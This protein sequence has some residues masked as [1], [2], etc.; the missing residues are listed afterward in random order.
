MVYVPF[1]RAVLFKFGQSFLARN[2]LTPRW[3]LDVRPLFR[4]SLH[5]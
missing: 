1:N 2:R 3:F 5:G 4:Y